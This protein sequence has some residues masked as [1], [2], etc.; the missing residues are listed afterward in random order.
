MT[1][2][3]LSCVRGRIVLLELAMHFNSL[4]FRYICEN[5]IEKV[6]KYVNERYKRQFHLSS[7]V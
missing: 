4:A 1:Q 7:T 2:F 3:Y 6:K 5:K